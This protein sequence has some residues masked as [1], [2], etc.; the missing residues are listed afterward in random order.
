MSVSFTKGN[1][2]QIADANGGSLV[3]DAFSRAEVAQP[4]TLADYTF[5]YDLNPLL[6]D[7][8][9]T[10]AGAVSH[11]A[12][13]ASFTLNSGTVD[14]D[15]AIFQSRRYHRY[16]AGKAGKVVLTSVVG[17]A[18]TDVTKRW[19]FFDG[20]NGLFF[21]QEG[22]GTFS[23]NI[24]SNVSGT[25]VDTKVT[26]ANFN[27]D[28][29]DGTGPSGF[30]LDFSK[31]NIFEIDFQWLGVGVVTFR[32]AVGDGAVIDLHKFKNPN[33]NTAVYMTTATLPVRYEVENE[34]TL[35]AAGTMEG[36]C[37]SVVSSGGEDPPELEFGGGNESEI[38]TTNATETHLVSFR[39]A[40]TFNSVANRML[41]LPKSFDFASDLGSCIFRVRLNATIT[42]GTWTAANSESG[43]EIND[44]PTSFSGGYIIS[45][46]DVLASSGTPQS[47][48]KSA[49]QRSGVRKLA[50]SRSADNTS[51]DI[52]TI[53][54]QRLTAT[55]VD[56]MG[57]MSWGEV[58]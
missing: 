48:N 36:I 34:G 19:G 38:T 54:V 1:K 45:G 47:T 8:I 25:P 10:G 2:T 44:D 5:P 49:N 39:L 6:W 56:A 24:R 14:G 16:Q 41:V 12:D 30:N 3:F 46:Q 52:I 50:L 21:Q 7:D 20:S 23:V 17:A 22:D 53:T 33:A 27:V 42:G 29:V 4:Y 37:S 51:S 55:N 18:A 11:D 15:A 43:V 9:S 28:S 58:R 40:S 26:Q 31:G 13:R 32:V 57:S 35:G